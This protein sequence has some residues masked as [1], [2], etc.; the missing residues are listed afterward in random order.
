[1]DNDTTKQENTQ[2]PPNALADLRKRADA[3]KAATDKLWAKV[4]EAEAAMLP[5]KRRYEE[6]CAEWHTS[7]HETER[8]EGACKVIAAAMIEA[9]P[10]LEYEGRDE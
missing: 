2:L 3:S 8:L 6:A 1:M 4:K 5:A 7:Y 9:K 10:M